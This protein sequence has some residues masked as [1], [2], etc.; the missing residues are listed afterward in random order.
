MICDCPSL[1]SNV[2]LE[3]AA[4]PQGY[5]EAVFLPVL[6]SALPRKPAASARLGLYI[7]AS[8]LPLS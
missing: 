1:P 3:V 2:V 7:F 8:V 4:L 6:V 5:L